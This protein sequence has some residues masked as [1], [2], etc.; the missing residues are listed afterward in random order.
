MVEREERREDDPVPQRGP[1]NR[2]TERFDNQ[3][4]SKNLLGGC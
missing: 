2:L 4:V 3:E 1:Q